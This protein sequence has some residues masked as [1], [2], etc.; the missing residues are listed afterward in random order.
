M[1]ET[2]EA[3]TQVNNVK[4]VRKKVNRMKKT[5]L[6]TMTVAAALV[7]SA[8]LAKANAFL[9]VISGSSSA[10]TTSGSDTAT[11]NSTVGGW[12]VSTQTGSS[13]VF[14]IS[15]NSQNIGPATAQNLEVIY[16][17]GAY[18]QTG[19]WKFGGSSTSEGI[20]NPTIDYT[21]YA[22]QYSAGGPLYGQS[23]PL[24]TLL[25]SL[26]LGP[27]QAIAPYDG[28]IS[29]MLGNFTEI[30][31]IT[32]VNVPAADDAGGIQA[33]VQT[34][35]QVYPVVPDG[36]LTLAMLGSVLVGVAGIRYKFGKR[37]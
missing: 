18:P 20:V 16:S 25:A 11:L 26:S 19:V 2:A 35:F 15:L 27:N 23:G 24:G 3:E 28:A 14:G 17:S 7:A 36:G 37:A 29:G 10:S 31:Y 5:I 1:T 34:S 9:E 21:A 30:L 22:Y 32:V 6:A 13:S 4:P 8:P 33:N 12:N